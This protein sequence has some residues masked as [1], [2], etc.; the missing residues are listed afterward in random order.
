MTDLQ[1]LKSQLGALYEVRWGIGMGKLGAASGKARQQAALDGLQ[2][3]PKKDIL[4]L[5][6]WWGRRRV[7]DKRDEAARLLQYKPT[8]QQL[9]NLLADL[10]DEGGALVLFW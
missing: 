5:S 10:S 8:P 9:Q 3:S 7:A 2:K 1:F 6:T 4:F